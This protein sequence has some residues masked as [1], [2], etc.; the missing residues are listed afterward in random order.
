MR[1]KNAV[2]QPA[3][4]NLFAHIARAIALILGTS[5]LAALVLGGMWMLLGWMRFYGL[6]TGVVAQASPLEITDYQNN[7]LNATAYAIDCYNRFFQG[8]S[9]FGSGL[10]LIAGACFALLFLKRSP[11][12]AQITGILLAG[13]IVA[14][15]FI[16]T[17]T[18]EPLPFLASL[19]IGALG[20]FALSLLAREPLS[21]LP[22][23]GNSKISL[24]T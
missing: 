8:N 13:S 19:V 12:P 16:L 4:E 18:S 7:F 10:G 20:F 22:S 21:N 1:L 23:I 14:G 17:F 24:P 9:R 6:E 2:E 15:R 5:A 11:R 3:R